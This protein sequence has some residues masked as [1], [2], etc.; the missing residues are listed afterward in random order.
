[1][2]RSHLDKGMVVILRKQRHESAKT[3]L[4]EDSEPERSMHL[5]E[6]DLVSLSPRMQALYPHFD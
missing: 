2:S 5:S 6:V 4:V 3:Q 1:M